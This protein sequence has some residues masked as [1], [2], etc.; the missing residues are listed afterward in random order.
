M[1][2]TTNQKRVKLKN[3]ENA[4]KIINKFKKMSKKILVGGFGNYICV[5]GC[6]NV[7]YNKNRRLIYLSLQFLKEKM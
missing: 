3:V 4:S 2:H 1:L 5:P 7:F 6:K